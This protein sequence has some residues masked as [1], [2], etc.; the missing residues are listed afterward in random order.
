VPEAPRPAGSAVRAGVIGLGMMGSGIAVS[1]DAAGLLEACFD[2]SPAVYD[3]CPQLAVRGRPSAAALAADVDVVFLVVVDRPQLEDVLFSQGGVVEGARP[4][5]VACIC[6]TV[7]A[8]D[9][10]ELA[11]RG[12]A[13]GLTVVDVGIAG[14]PDAAASGGLLTTTGADD[15]T[16]ERIR[17]CL[18]ALSVRAIHAGPVGAGMKLKLVKNALSFMT[19]CAVHEALLLGEELGFSSELVREVATDSNLV[20]HFFWFPMSRPSARPYGPDTDAR[21]LGANRHFAD[22]ARKDVAAAAAAADSVGMDH[23]VMDLTVAQ[24]SR[25]F[26]LPED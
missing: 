21:M 13:A 9:V 7:T 20:D 4:G 12:G 19:M 2:V 14:G 24:A 8:D 1:L 16:F 3:A 6:S 15:A 25:Y 5:L 17:P 26:L 22:L 18:A 10:A 11:A 23:P